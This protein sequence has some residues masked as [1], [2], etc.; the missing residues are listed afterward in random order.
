M[1]IACSEKR[2]DQ[3]KLICLCFFKLFLFFHLICLNKIIFFMRM[4]GHCRPFEK[5]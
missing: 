5:L 2:K 1:L 3:T 4:F